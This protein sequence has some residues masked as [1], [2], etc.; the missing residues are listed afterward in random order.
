MT[1]L[2]VIMKNDKLRMLIPYKIKTQQI[3]HM[4]RGIVIDCLMSDKVMV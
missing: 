3:Q 4:E 1:E 2:L